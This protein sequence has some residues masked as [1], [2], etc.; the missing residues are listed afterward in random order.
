MFIFVPNVTT[1]EHLAKSLG[2][3]G[4]PHIDRYDAPAGYSAMISHSDIPDCH[5]PG[6]FHVLEYRVYVVLRSLVTIWFS[7]WRRHGG[8]S[9]IATGPEHVVPWAYRLNVVLY[10][11]SVFMDN[12][13]ITALARFPFGHNIEMKGFLPAGPELKNW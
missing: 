9:P 2:V 4:G 6:R 3:F 1:E 7:G 12:V 8:T 11:S 10:P 5:E 13:G